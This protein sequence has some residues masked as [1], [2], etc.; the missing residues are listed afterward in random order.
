MKIRLKFH[1]GVVFDYTDKQISNF[2]IEY[3]RENKKFAKRF[4]LFILGPD[5][6]FQ[7]KIVENLVTLSL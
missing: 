6:V 7:A 3:L 5:R 4:C 1:V 2:T